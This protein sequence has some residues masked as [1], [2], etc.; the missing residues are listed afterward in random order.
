VFRRDLERHRLR[1]SCVV[2]MRSESR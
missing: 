1:R 2:L